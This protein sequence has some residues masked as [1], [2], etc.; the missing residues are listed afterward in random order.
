MHDPASHMLTTSA[1]TSP[2]DLTNLTKGAAS[3]GQVAATSIKTRKNMSPTRER[4][5]QKNKVTREIINTQG[6]FRSRHARAFLVLWSAETLRV[7][8]QSQKASAHESKKALM[9][10]VSPHRFVAVFSMTWTGSLGSALQRS[11]TLQAAQAPKGVQRL[12][13]MWV[14]AVIGVEAQSSEA[15][16]CI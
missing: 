5:C 6:L 7:P 13:D 16:V 10:Q 8:A 9:S 15:C 12:F 3:T 14:S 4:Y 1:A 2:G 11:K